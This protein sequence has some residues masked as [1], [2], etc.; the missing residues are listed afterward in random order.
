[1]NSRLMCGIH[2]IWGKG[3]NEE[4]IESMLQQSQHRG[5]DQHA[6]LSPWPGLWIGVNRLKILHTGSEADQP[7]WSPDG[8]SLLIWN[9]ELYNYQEARNMLTQMGII[10]ITHS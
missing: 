2:L 3:A 8:T 7:F 9:G 4:A 5:P 1:R 10:F 6:S